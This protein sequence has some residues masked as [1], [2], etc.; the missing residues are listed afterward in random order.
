LLDPKDW[1][2]E[3]LSTNYVPLCHMLGQ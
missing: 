1:L 3:V 2:N